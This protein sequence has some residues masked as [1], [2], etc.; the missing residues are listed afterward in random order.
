M[1]RYKII[2]AIFVF[3]FTALPPSVHAQK[4][5]FEHRYEY[6]PEDVLP[7]TRFVQKKGYWEGYRDGKLVGYAGLSRDWTIN[8]VGY[9]GKHLETL[10]G[11]DTS[12]TITGTKLIYHSEPIVLIGLK[13]ESY[14]T[15]MKQ[16]AG[17]NIKDS[18]AVGGAVSMDALTGATVTAVVQNSIILETLRKIATSAGIIQ[19]AM[20]KGRAVSQA[21][22]ALTWD[23]LKQSNGVKNIPVTTKELGIIGEEI[24]LDLYIA[25]LT[26][27]AIGKNILGDKRYKEVTAGLKPGETAVAVFSRGKGSFKGT[28]FVRGGVFDRFNIE[29]GAK[30]LMFS[31][32]DY[33]SISEIIASGAPSINEGGVFIIR[34]KDFDPAAPFKLNLVLPYRPSLTE[35]KFKSFSVEYSLGERFLK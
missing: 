25:V 9:A 19:A 35:K 8:L 30:M 13:E 10:V 21:Y 2:L 7:A 17:K 6:K 18:I 32:K 27:P 16:Y 31:D 34:D 15:F 12:G 22:T 14:L 23:E 29:Q 3:I 1:E 24:Y 33:R 4:A 26:P 5:M 28:G 11:M 20:G